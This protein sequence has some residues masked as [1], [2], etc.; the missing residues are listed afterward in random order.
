M[1]DETEDREVT[2]AKLKR[3]SD[4]WDMGFTYGSIFTEHHADLWWARRWKFF[5]DHQS[6]E[7][8]KRREKVAKELDKKAQDVFN[9]K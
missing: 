5:R 7:G 8:A 9:G 3:E 6:I 4:V 1:V 2:D